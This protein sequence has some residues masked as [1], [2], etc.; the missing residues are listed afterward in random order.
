MTAAYSPS[1]RFF[2]LAKVWA[3]TL[4]VAGVLYGGMTVDSAR[5]HLRGAR[6]VW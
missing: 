6:R 3:L 4:P 5:R 1:V 2:R